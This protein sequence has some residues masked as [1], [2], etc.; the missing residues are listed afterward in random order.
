MAIFGASHTT[1]SLLGFSFP[2]SWLQSANSMWVL[3]MAPVFAAIWPLLARRR[4]E[5]SLVTK[6]AIGLALIG[7]SFFVFSIPMAS[8]GSGTKVSPLW[9][10]AIYLVQCLG[11]LCLS[12]VGLSLTSRI[13]PA[14]YASLLMGVWFLAVTA[15]DCAASLLVQAGSHLDTTPVVLTEAV[16]AVLVALLVFTGR[17]RILTLMGHTR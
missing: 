7:V 16:L 14:K 2:S 17:G 13:A 1:G 12:P 9:L 4:E 15:G 5:P 11:E 3:L 6:F 8:S 10:I